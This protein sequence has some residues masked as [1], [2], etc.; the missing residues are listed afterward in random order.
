MSKTKRY[1]LLIGIFLVAGAFI[2]GYY[3]RG[4][5]SPNVTENQPESVEESKIV[6]KS[7]S[8]E[9]LDG[10]KTTL[11]VRKVLEGVDLLEVRYSKKN[12]ILVAKLETHAF[13]GMKKLM[14]DGKINNIYATKV[15]AQIKKRDKDQAY[16]LTTKNEDFKLDLALGKPFEMTFVNPHKDF[17]MSELYEFDLTFDFLP[18]EDKA[19]PDAYSYMVSLLN[20]T[21]E[22]RFVEESVRAKEVSSQQDGSSQDK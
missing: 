3:F 4:R 13:S 21:N 16:P 20:S 6:E 17:P 11:P 12:N 15:S 7:T 19:I 9:K 14:A 22:N 1:I 18:T 5:V 2:A 10:E 8:E